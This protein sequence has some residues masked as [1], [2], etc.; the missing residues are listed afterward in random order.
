M[1]E[2]S[3]NIGALNELVARLGKQLMALV[4]GEDL[5]VRQVI[6]YAVVRARPGRGLDLRTRL[7]ARRDPAADTRAE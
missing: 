3:N 2:H 5:R 6:A 7:H 4:A 1:A